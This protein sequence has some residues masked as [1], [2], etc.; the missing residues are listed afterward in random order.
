MKTNPFQKRT[1]RLRNFEEISY[2]NFSNHPLPSQYLFQIKAFG[3]T[4]ASNKW[5]RKNGDSFNQSFSLEYIL[6]GECV[7]TEGKVKQTLQKGDVFFFRENKSCILASNPVTGVHKYYITLSYNQLLGRLYSLPQ[8]QILKTRPRDPELIGSLYEEI[9][10]LVIEGG[11]HQESLLMGKIYQLYFELVNSAPISEFTDEYSIMLSA[12]SY[13]PERY[14]N[15]KTL[16][17][18]FKLSHYALTCFFKE[19]LRTTP[20]EYVITQRFNKAIWHLENQIT[21]VNVI[22]NSCGFNSVPFF[23]NEF[24]K[25]FGQSPLEFRRAKQKTANGFIGS[26]SAG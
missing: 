7:F 12:I 4:N 5:V 9:K 17:S 13:S 2:V 21:P 22:A 3:E 23:T 10:G 26:P 16:S 18:E 19:K 1:Y 6:E 24:K 25:R 15:L 8:G 11:K 14:P 20:M